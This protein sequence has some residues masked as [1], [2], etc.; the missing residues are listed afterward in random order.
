M[1]FRILPIGVDRKILR[2]C[3]KRV[4]IKNFLIVQGSKS[5]SR[6]QLEPRGRQRLGGFGL[7]K[8]RS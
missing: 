1:P 4:R 3:R 7:F 2:I 6:T 5:F 8:E